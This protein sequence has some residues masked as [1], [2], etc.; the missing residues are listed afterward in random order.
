M[1]VEDEKEIADLLEVYLSN[2]GYQVKKAGCG[3]DA[4]EILS[5][6]D[7]SL[8]LLDLMLPGM[9]GFTICRQMREKYLFPIK[10]NENMFQFFFRIHENMKGY[11][12]FLLCL[13]FSL[14]N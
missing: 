5:Q 4:F 1:I 9:D 2:E 14:E 8:V 10:M 6:E 12:K 13:L 11:L 7:V 3:K